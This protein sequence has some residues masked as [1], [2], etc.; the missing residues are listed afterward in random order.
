MSLIKF[1]LTLLAFSLVFTACNRDLSLLP[2]E[3]PTPQP[4]PK[5]LLKS[6]EYKTFN[7]TSVYT[8]NPDSTL[9][10]IVST[11]HIAS[12]TAN[13]T[14]ANKMISAVN[15]SG[16]LT[17]TIYTYING[18]ISTIFFSTMGQNDRGHE[19]DFTYNSAGKVSK[20]VYTYLNEAGELPKYVSTY[21]YNTAGLPSE[22]ASVTGNT[23]V[24]WHIE[25]YSNE[26]DFSPFTF[27]HYS[28]DELY[29]LYNFPV[30][31]QMKRLPKKII[32]TIQVGSAA[33]NTEK[34]EEIDFRMRRI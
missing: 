6:L 27:I 18:K 25:E 34:I 5:Y 14:Y 20:V 12:S 7:A 17:R 4:I 16:S 15:V 19:L 22:I 21:E 29:E 11:S 28:L 10:K 2:D 26:C 9:Q 23:T 24:S 13:F 1:C 32:E 3:E 33:A 31:S 30:I 8:Y